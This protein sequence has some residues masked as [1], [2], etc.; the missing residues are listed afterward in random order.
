MLCIQWISNDANLKRA[1]AKSTG[2][3]SGSAHN[4]TL[5]DRNYF[6]LSSSDNLFRTFLYHSICDSF[7]AAIHTKVN[8]SKVVKFNRHGWLWGAVEITSHDA[9]QNQNLIQIVKLKLCEGIF[10]YFLVIIGPVRAFIDQKWRVREEAK[11]Q[12]T[13]NKVK[14]EKQSA[15]SA[16]FVVD[17]GTPKI[18]FILFK[19]TSKKAEKRYRRS[20]ISRVFRLSRCCSLPWNKC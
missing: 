3:N 7:I 14:S 4:T 15:S 16:H 11:G 9:N 10:A 8:Y 1:A 6:F 17:D 18:D 12:I 13:T 19:K 2:K 5:I 20:N